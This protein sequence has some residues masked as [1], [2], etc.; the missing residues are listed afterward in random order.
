MLNLAREHER[1][2]DEEEKE[3]EAKANVDERYKSEIGA[4]YKYIYLI[5]IFFL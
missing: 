3:E 4:I 5:L 1:A 2:K